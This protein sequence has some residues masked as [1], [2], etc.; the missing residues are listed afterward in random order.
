MPSSS[1]I[2][3]RVALAASTRAPAGDGVAYVARLLQM[4]LLDLCGR[5]PGIL[6][7]EHAAPGTPVALSTRLRFSTAV[8]AAQLSRRYDWLFFNHVGL[9]RSQQFVPPAIRRPYAVFVHGVEVWKDPLDDARRTALQRAR[10]IVANS[11][12][13]ASGLLEREPDLPPV[14]VASLAL[15]PAVPVAGQVDEALVRAAGE[16]FALIVGRMSAAERYKGHDELIEA[17]AEVRTRVAD[18]RLVVVGG[19]DDVPR[20]RGKVAELGLSAA[21]LFCGRVSDATLAELRR[22]ARVF[23]MP[24]RGEGFG[25][26]YLEAMRTGLP[27]I[28]ATDDA[29]R[30]VIAHGE[31]GMLV[32]QADRE[33]LVDALAG[34]LQSP[35]RAR[36]MGEAGRRRAADHFSYPVF[37]D[38]LGEVLA[39][40]FHPRVARAG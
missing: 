11:E 15:L 18:A 9:A 30:E 3:Q 36:Q 39:R 2:G 4:A 40:A 35:G 32:A 21:V 28:G 8:M 10:L 31:T 1:L 34:F 23:A 7:L 20:L 16:G 22:A 24:S 12:F 38:R 5:E 29:A 6:D 27:C 13:T 37:R 33:A 25:L 17:W 26:V 19:G 14:V